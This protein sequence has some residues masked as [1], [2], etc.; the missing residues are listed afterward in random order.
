MVSCQLSLLF[1]CLA[2]VGAVCSQ[3]IVAVDTE[4]LRRVMSHGRNT[5]VSCDCLAVSLSVCPHSC[6]DGTLIPRTAIEAVLTSS[7]ECQ[8]SEFLI[9]GPQDK[10]ACRH[11]CSEEAAC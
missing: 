6:C 3:C 2:Y 11:T 5:R 10:T 1:V 7:N 9:S 8:V 4:L